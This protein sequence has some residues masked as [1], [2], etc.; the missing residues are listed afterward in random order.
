MFATG[1]MRSAYGLTRRGSLF[2]LAAGALLAL[3]T[4]TAQETDFRE[5]LA[6]G[7]FPVARRLIEAES[8]AATRDR[9]LA[10]LSLAQRTAGVSDDSF[11]NA[12]E[13]GD[14]RSRLDTLAKIS[15]FGGG[16]GL[17]SS[18]PGT[19]NGNQGGMDGFGGFGGPGGGRGGITAADFDELM[20]LIQETIDPDSWEENGGTGRMR[21]FPSGVYVN[22]EGVMT[23]LAPDATG[24]LDRIRET[25]DLDDP[26]LVRT[27]PMRAISLTRLE[28]ALQLAA[29]Q[30][31]QPSPAMMALGGIYRLE[32]VFLYPETRDVVIA[33][34]AGPWHYDG[35][36]RAIN[37]ETGQPVLNLDD[38]VVC[39]R[40]AASRGGVFGCSIE[41]KEEN[42]ADANEFR[43]T[44]TL[45][46]EAW[47]EGL[48]QVLGQQE[49][50]VNGIDAGTHAARVIVEA[51]WHMKRVG[52]GLED[53]ISGVPNYFDRLTL[54][55]DGNLS[56][57]DA[58]VRWWF[59]MNYDAIQTNEDRTVFQI[60][61]QGVR[62]LSESEFFSE[63]GERVH[64]GKS[65]PAA[66]GFAND[67]TRHFE[68]M[69]DK[70]P[71]YGELRNLF[72]C[73]L[74]ANLIHREG[75]S[76]QIDWQ[77]CHFVGRKQGD[78]LLYQPAIH[79]AP[80]FTDT[81]IGQKELVHRSGRSVRTITVSAIGGVQFDPRRLVRE[82]KMETSRAAELATRRTTIRPDEVSDPTQWHLVTQ[83]LPVQSHQPR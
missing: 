78:S 9:M 26:E 21:P 70:Y 44:S 32:F 60:S 65:S 66:G 39:M 75:L 3:R 28:R 14:D 46:G 37:N 24:R 29:A 63:L 31:E 5:H 19:Q 13:I 79:R 41:P 62:L 27:T 64:S 83:P 33:G 50:F 67:F 53:S 61:G 47:R 52:I 54:D 4:A 58:L 34:P 82:D 1:A 6:S 30:G 80:R 49:I 38:L 51:D 76:R 18:S 56:Q 59:T 43:N 17:T 10:E 74:A 55:E 72:D 81:I 68:A 42:L 2:L 15:V 22:P 45:K 20:D 73:A 16:G 35:R 69:A 11:Q 71:V 40:N 12:I 77:L 23:T 7:E 57:V 48:R 8:D 25:I 36:G